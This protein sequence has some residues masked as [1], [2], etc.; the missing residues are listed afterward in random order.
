M[1]I[2]GLSGGGAERICVNL[3]NAW[4]ERG[5]QVTVLTVSQHSAPS[6]F[7]IDA[8][9]EL[10]DIGWYRPA[11]NEELNA[12]AIAPVIRGLHEAGCQDHLTHEIT[13][14]ALLRYAILNQTPDVVVSHIDM[15]NMRVLA[16][17]HETNVPII[18]YEHTDT[19]QIPLGGWQGAR[20]ALYR[21]ARA[22]VAPHQ[23]STE[24][25]A[26]HGAAAFTIPNPLVNPPSE[27]HERTDQRRRLVSLNRLS[28]EKRPDL[29]VRAFAT[30]CREFPDWDFDVYGEG[31]LRASLASLI[32][33]LAPGRIHLCGFTTVP[34]DV[35][36]NA[37]LYVSASWVEGFGNSIW[38][39]LA[40]GVP[41]V[42]MEAG[43]SVRS[44]VRDGIDGLIVSENSIEALA[45]ALA[46]LMG[47][48]EKRKAL[49]ARAPEIVTRFPIEA[50]LGAWDC[51]LEEA[52]SGTIEMGM[53]LRKNGI[54]G[55][56]QRVS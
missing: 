19:T 38:E 3:A 25:L 13:L 52:T 5:R 28:D 7:A 50:S 36:K 51:L 6:V 27:H 11:R 4:V 55:L 42:A 22:V 17:M 29:F 20:A 49:A 44:L 15:T 9:V 43:A 34:Y 41:V 54:E 46:S 40:C 24:W 12:V 47:D 14:L 39:S 21:R 45:Q 30:I 33:Q 18:V 32:D 31:P 37:D 23:I 1:V 56:N 48:D 2:E 10:R 8:R 35:L 16:A 53:S 26:A